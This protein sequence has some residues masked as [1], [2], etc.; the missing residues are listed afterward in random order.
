MSS[1]LWTLILLFVFRLALDY[2]GLMVDIENEF[3]L[4][5]L[6]LRSARTEGIPGDS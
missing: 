5:D 4:A 6:T 1:L 2:P 3:R